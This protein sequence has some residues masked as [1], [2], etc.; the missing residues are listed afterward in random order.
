[1]DRA[2]AVEKSVISDVA[3]IVCV[4]FADFLS[5]TLPWNKHHF[6]RLL[7]VTHPEDFETLDICQMN[8]VEVLQTEM[9]H[10]K[11]AHFNKWAAVEFGLDY[12]GKSGWITLLDADILIPQAAEIP[13]RQVGRAYCPRKRA[14]PRDKRK[15]IHEE[16]KWSRYRF[17]QLSEPPRGHMLTFHGDDQVLRKQPWFANHW[18]WCGTGDDTFVD[19]WRTQ[20]IVRTTFDVLH[21]GQRQVNWCGRTEQYMDGTYVPDGLRDTRQQ[22]VGMLLRQSTL[23]RG[24]DDSYK[25]GV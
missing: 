25:G 1:M 5:A 15:W 10:W 6:H 13:G 8:E 24:L 17:E 4:D 3:V 7:V 20:D 9:F 12:L 11:R 21:L 23:L 22:N 14:V 2:D 19:R 16:S 18:R